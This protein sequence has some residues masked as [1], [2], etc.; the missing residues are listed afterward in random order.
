MMHILTALAS[1][2]LQCSCC[3]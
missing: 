1:D 3:E 2:V